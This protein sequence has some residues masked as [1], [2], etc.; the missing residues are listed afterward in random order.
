MAIAL[1][2]RSADDERLFMKRWLAVFIG[3]ITLA[4]ATINGVGA[5]VKTGAWPYVVLAVGAEGMLVVMFS[6]IVLSQTW[7]RRTVG[8]VLFVGL[9]WFCVDNGKTGIQTWMSDVFVEEE[10]VLREEAAILLA[11]ANKLDTLPDETKGEVAEQRRLDR[12]ELAALRVE[13]KQMQAQDPQGIETAQLALK[14]QG[15]YRGAIDG[16]RRDLTEA[17]MEQRGAEITARIEILQA[18]L[19]EGGT[20]SAAVAA[21]APA[22]EK[23]M[24]A[25]TKT[26]QADKVRDEGANVVRLLYTVEGVRS[27]GVWVFLMTGTATLTLAGLA[28]WKTRNQ[29]RADAPQEPERGA[30]AEEE[31]AEETAPA[32]DAAPETEAETEHVEDTEDPANDDPPPKPRGDPGKGGESTAFN[33]ETGKVDGS[34]PVDPPGMEQAA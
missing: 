23:R 31:T 8:F 15:K 7:L 11:D 24:L 29:E 9:A 4:L 10:A 25:A 5:W 30:P 20:G 2:F 14:A 13:Q 18:K 27:F 33:H 32:E 34:I 22:A 6:L 28:F 21:L 26:A 17:A 12:E 3:I 19:D 16:I 1:K